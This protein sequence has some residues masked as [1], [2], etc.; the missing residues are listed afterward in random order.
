MNTEF[1]ALVQ[2]AVA[3]TQEARLEDAERLLIEA[4]NIEPASAVPHFLLGANFA[5]TRQNDL[6]EASYIACLS[7]A[8]HLAIA[9]FQLGLLQATNGRTAAARA[10]WEPLLGSSE[11]GVL[12]CFARGFVAILGGDKVSAQALIARGIGLNSDNPALN[13]D[14]RGV[15]ARLEH[16]GEPSARGPADAAAQPVASPS[17]DA[18]AAHFLLSTYG[19]H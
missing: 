2:R 1:E 14:M 18:A 3:A 4:A 11:E 13:R 8:P 17:T 15:L 5:Q 12:E 19:Q 7:R 9:R 16:V 10:T 6:A